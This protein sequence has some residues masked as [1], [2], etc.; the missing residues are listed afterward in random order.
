M[1]RR[2]ADCTSGPQNSPGILGPTE[3]GPAARRSARR[4][5]NVRAASAAAEF[6]NQINEIVGA[7][8]TSPAPFACTVTTARRVAGRISGGRPAASSSGGKD[9]GGVGIDHLAVLRRLRALSRSRPCRRSCRPRARSGRRAAVYPVEVVGAERQHVRERHRVVEI[10]ER[11][12]A[13]SA[14]PRARSSR[15]ARPRSDSAS[16]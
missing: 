7:C 15:A 5:E 14:D 4:I 3:G 11:V 8:G 10:D 9:V 16:A 6:P 12:H 13:R 1:S 2:K